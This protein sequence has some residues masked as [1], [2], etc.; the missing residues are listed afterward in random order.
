MFFPLPSAPRSFPPPS[1]HPSLFLSK[2]K[3]THTNT[4]K[5]ENQNTQT[6]TNKTKIA[7]TKPKKK[8]MN[9]TME[10]ILFWHRVCS[11]V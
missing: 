3:H 11:G 5:K 10:F 1:A 9:K 8:P 4:L 7:K 2:E 6:R